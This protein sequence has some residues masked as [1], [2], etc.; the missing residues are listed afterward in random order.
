MSNNTRIPLNQARTI[1]Q[2]IHDLLTD[3]CQ[4]LHIA[5]SIWRAKSDVGDIELVVWQD[6]E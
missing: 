2:S 4:Q 3:T 5:G 6:N 1:A